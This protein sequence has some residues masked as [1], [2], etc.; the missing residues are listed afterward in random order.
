MYDDDDDDDDM[1]IVKIQWELPWDVKKV[2]VTGTGC[3]WE[4]KTTEFVWE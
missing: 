4:F 3:L 1:A 2:S